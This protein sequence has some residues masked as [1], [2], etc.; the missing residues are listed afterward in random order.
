MAPKDVTTDIRV[1]DIATS[2]AG[3]GPWSD[4]QMV[5]YIVANILAQ[6]L[7]DNRIHSEVLWL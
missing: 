5:V 4:P 2:V 1:D 6:T 3:D 7:G